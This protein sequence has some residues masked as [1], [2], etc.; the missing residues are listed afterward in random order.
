MSSGDP[1]LTF[2]IE[3]SARLHSR[4]VVKR[5]ADLQSFA[6]QIYSFDG[7]TATGVTAVGIF[8]GSSGPLLLIRD[9]APNPPKMFYRL[10]VLLRP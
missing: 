8:Q 10:E 2:G 7:P 4:W 1:I 3:N 9:Q 5:S 6:E